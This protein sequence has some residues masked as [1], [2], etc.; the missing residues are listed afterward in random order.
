MENQRLSNGNQKNRWL[1]LNE[2]LGLQQPCQIETGHPVFVR[3]QID[4]A[5]AGR[6]FSA[7]SHPSVVSG[8]SLDNALHRP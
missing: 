1:F 4:H 3:E 6:A 2:A 8:S 7:G 5:L